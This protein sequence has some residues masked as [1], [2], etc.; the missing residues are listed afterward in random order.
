MV[1]FSGDEILSI[2]DNSNR[3]V[4]NIEHVYL[5]TSTRLQE[6]FRF[7]KAVRQASESIAQNERKI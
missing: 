3:L 1:V 4:A 6:R 5:T 2:G 7:N